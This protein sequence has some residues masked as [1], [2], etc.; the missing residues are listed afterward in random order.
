MHVAELTVYPVKGCYR[1]PQPRAKVEPWGL[2]GDRRWLIVDAATGVAV[3]QRQEP[4]LTR[5]RPEVVPGGLVVRAA[6]AEDLIV[7]EP[8]D[9]PRADVRVF[10][11]TGAAAHAPDA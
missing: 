10:S 1:V 6:G 8:A 9:G 5:L 3:T 11:Y 2:A 7:A 4:R